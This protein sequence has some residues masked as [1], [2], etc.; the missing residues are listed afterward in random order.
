MS[1]LTEYIIKGVMP[2]GSADDSCCLCQ[3]NDHEKYVN[4]HPDY[5]VISEKEQ[6]DK[7]WICYAC[8][9]EM[10]LGYLNKPE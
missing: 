1:V 9:E 4:I 10:N 7:Y 2:E 6:W 8:K 5:P 3:I